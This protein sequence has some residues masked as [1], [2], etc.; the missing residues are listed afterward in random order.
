MPSTS[1]LQ[2]PPVSWEFV[3]WAPIMPPA[4]R[5][6]GGSYDIREMVNVPWMTESG[7]DQQIECVV[8]NWGGT[9]A[10]VEYDRRGGGYGLLQSS[11][12]PT[13]P[14]GLAWVAPI[15]GQILDGSALAAA[16]PRVD[17]MRWLR[18]WLSASAAL[19]NQDDQGV[20]LMSHPGTSG[21]GAILANMLPGGGGTPRTIVGISGFDAGGG[22][23][24]WR[25]RSYDTAG[26]ATETV[27]LGSAGTDWHVLDF[28]MRGAQVGTNGTLRVKFDGADVLTRE[29]GSALELPESYPGNSRGVC[30]CINTASPGGG[31]VNEIIS[32]WRLRCGAFN[33]IGVP[34]LS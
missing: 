14:R 1:L 15:M 10:V 5:S 16:P 28:L 21:G 25:F 13:V 22:T 33:E 20:F 29:F 4:F 9:G 7:A 8:G 19:L 27:Q 2:P 34:L 11:S 17:R 24:G 23:T 26:V 12:S 32:Q 31:P 6:M 18:V 3:M 30:W